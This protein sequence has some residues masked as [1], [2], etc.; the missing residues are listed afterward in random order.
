MSRL[1]RSSGSINQSFLFGA[2]SR[3]ADLSGRYSSGQGGSA[4]GRPAERFSIQPKVGAALDS[5][6]K[7]FGPLG[8][9]GLDN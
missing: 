4:S 6:S 3:R 5:G 2:G 1:N 9:A 8:L 7:G